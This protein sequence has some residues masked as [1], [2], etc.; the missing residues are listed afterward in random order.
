MAKYYTSFINN[1]DDKSLSDV[2]KD[3]ICKKRY[4]KKRTKERNARKA[5]N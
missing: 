1:K 2:A 4:N 3:V 5:R